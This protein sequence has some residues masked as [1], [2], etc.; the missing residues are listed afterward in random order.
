MRLFVGIFC[1]W[2][3][4]GLAS[5]AASL[6][7][8]AHDFTLPSI[9]GG[10]LDLAQFKGKT[11]L[12]VNTASQCGFTPQYDGLQSLWEEYRDRGLVVLGIPSNDFGQQE[13]G[14]KDDIKEFCDV[15][16]NI[17]FPMSDKLVVRGDDAH[18]LYKWLAQ[19]LGRG[20]RPKWN[21]YKYVID[22]DGKAVTYFSSVT[23]P[24]SGRVRKAI[25]A[26]LLR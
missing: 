3:G 1:L 25:E 11:L 21:F 5:Q 8:S 7:P 13:P 24:Q 14:A 19:E 4:V 18:P 10:T 20:S 9:D 12:V 15:N 16:F 23:K 17:D 6:A 26:S 2:L 22:A